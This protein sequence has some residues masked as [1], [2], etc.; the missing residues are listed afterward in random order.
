MRAESGKK[1][2]S[3]LQR[4][5]GGKK[6]H[7]ALSLTGTPAIQAKSAEAPEE[8][9]HHHAQTSE[10]E[11]KLNSLFAF[12]DPKD[13]RRLVFCFS[14]NPKSG[15]QAMGSHPYGCSAFQRVESAGL[16]FRRIGRFLCHRR[17]DGDT[18]GCD[19]DSPGVGSL[20]ATM[21]LARSKSR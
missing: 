19:R 11:S 6:A 5:L 12:V 4:I 1:M 10:A 7:Q 15:I 17:R 13:G 16:G 14:Q 2:I 20:V 21:F 9:S 8:E 3:F 18:S